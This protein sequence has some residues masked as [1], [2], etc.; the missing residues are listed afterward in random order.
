MPVCP[1]CKADF[2]VLKAYNNH[3]RQCPAYKLKKAH[4]LQEHR[5][6][7]LQRSLSQ[8]STASNP[9][10]HNEAG[11]TSDIEMA[12]GPLMA[13]SDCGE[14]SHDEDIHIPNLH[15]CNTVTTV[16]SDELPVP[17]L[18]VA[19]ENGPELV[20]D[21]TDNDEDNR[22]QLP[23]TSFQTKPNHFGIFR[24]YPYGK[25]SY[26]P[27]LYYTNEDLSDVPTF[28]GS[29]SNSGVSKSWWDQMG[30]SLDVITSE[31]IP[32]VAKSIHLFLEWYWD[33][34]STI[35]SYSDADKLVRDVLL[36]PEFDIAHF[37]NYR[38]TAKETERLDQFLNSPAALIPTRDKWIQSSIKLPVPVP[39]W[40]YPSESDAEAFTVEGLYCRSLLDVIKGCLSEPSAQYW[41][42]FG[43]KEFWKPNAASPHERTI[44]EIY[45]SDAF[46]REQRNIRGELIGSGRQL[47]PAVVALMFWSDS[48]HLTNF[49]TAS[50]WPIY[51][52]IGNVSKYIRS[53]PSSFSAQHLAYIPKLADNV[54]EWY[55]Q[56]FERSPTPELLTHLRR[57]LFQLIW[58]QILDPEFMEAY[59]HGF[60][61]TCVDGRK[62]L[63]VPRVFTYSAD[64]PEKVLIACIKF[65]SQKPCIR[66]LVPKEKIPNLG[67][68]SDNNYHE[69]H[70]RFDDKPIW[71]TI[72]KARG[73]LFNG[74]DIRTRRFKRLLEPHSLTASRSAFST[75][76]VD[77]P[78]FNVYDI[79]APDLLHEFEI[80]VFKAFF[81]HLIRVLHT[82]EK[83]AVSVLNSRNPRYRATS[84]F[85]RDTI[86]RF[87]NNASEMKRLGARDF[88]DL[89][90]CAIPAFGGLLGPHDV[91]IRRLLFEFATWHALAKLRRHTAST[92]AELRTSTSRLGKRLRYF[93]N[94][95]CPDYKTRDLKSETEARARAQAR[96]ATTTGLG[97]RPA[98][99]QTSTR[100][101]QFNLMTYKL[102][103]L[104]HYAD[105]IEEIGTTDN[106]STQIGEAQHRH[107]KR[108]Y[109]RV[110]K[111]TSTFVA[112]IAKQQRQER[113]LFQ[114]RARARQSTR[115]SDA[116]S[117]VREQ[118]FLPFEY[119]ERLD[120]APSLIHHQMSHE[121]NAKNRINLPEWIARN[122]NDPALKDFVRQLKTHLFL[123]LKGQSFEGDEEKL[124]DEDLDSVIIEND[125]L[126]KHKVLRINYT[127][128]D[129]RRDQDSLNPRTHADIMMLSHEDD[130]NA[131][132]YCYPR[133]HLIPA[134]TLG[135]STNGL[136]KTIA[137]P[138]SDNDLDW[139]YFYIN[140]D[141]FMRYRGGGI[142]HASI[143]NATDKFLDD[144]DR[145]DLQETATTDDDIEMEADTGESGVSQ[146]G[147]SDIEVVDEGEIIDETLEFGYEADHQDT[148]DTAVFYVFVQ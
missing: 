50:L 103:A 142:G 43:F 98:K 146:D 80:G 68:I 86:R 89:L 74:K 27:D 16:F 115:Q 88:E 128:Y 82:L 101:H 106:Y 116:L 125:M 2:S 31:K 96:K 46:L 83:D 131:H 113:A 4:A 93:V 145:E 62:C 29:S 15:F 19:E 36:H 7:L 127:T 20:E 67:M 69:M 38:G 14:I 94:K 32:P 71:F 42:L 75:R 148:V 137:R 95:I 5:E 97:K 114:L 18:M 60:E 11:H 130:P 53:R 1:G 100:E 47:E 45:N 147:D 121:V 135:K 52:Y 25:P 48:T 92:I 105:A 21:G 102:H 59:K 91:F 12:P 110:R 122:A 28:Q 54:Q 129:M 22:Q 64:Y 132:P 57:D 9:D 72:S 30:T 87:S 78:N 111:G 70:Y 65:L 24:V 141:T 66:C 107:V 56:K 58:L 119:S 49:G 138:E 6:A 44:S 126:F 144:R 139:N 109:T 63:L 40:E 134:F 33:P 41:H 90:Q 76:L 34:K 123:R 133:V 124:L 3:V 79:L 81:T 55:L 37:K 73:W 35:K 10:R 84:T 8:D 26:T 77:D 143:R 108:W 99:Q 112:G 85:G 51:L 120:R 61:W 13:N 23:L 39:G 136:K 17:A 118:T 140:M 104:G 117:D